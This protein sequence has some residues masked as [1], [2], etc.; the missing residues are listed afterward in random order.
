MPA[1]EGRQV[2]PASPIGTAVLHRNPQILRQVPT[3]QFDCASPPLERGCTPPSRV[4][5][6]DVRDAAV[7]AVTL[8]KDGEESSARLQR[9]RDR[10]ERGYHLVGI[11]FRL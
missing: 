6:M 10:Q 1:C 9:R 5:C 7:A 2:L 4:W 8:P 11:E 3:K